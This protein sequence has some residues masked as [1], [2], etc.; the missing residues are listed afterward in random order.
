MHKRVKKIVNGEEQIFY[1]V[2]RNSYQV[3]K[4]AERS[5][6]LKQNRITKQWRTITNLRAKEVYYK[7]YIKGRIKKV[8]HL[9]ERISKSL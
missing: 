4:N 5:A 6:R 9:I 1:L 7:N 2:P 8:D 3:L